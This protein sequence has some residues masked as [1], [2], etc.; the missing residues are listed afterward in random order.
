MIKSFKEIPLQ[1]RIEYLKALPNGS[2]VRYYNRTSRLD[3]LPGIKI[4]DI[5]K[6]MKVMLDDGTY[7]LNYKRLSCQ[8]LD[9]A[10]AVS[11]KLS[12]S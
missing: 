8:A 1:T 10:V 3:G 7:S 6:Y 4:R 11:K 9:D 12:S 2:P 5:G